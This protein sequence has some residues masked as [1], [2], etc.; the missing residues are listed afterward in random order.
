MLKNAFVPL[1]A[2]GL[3]LFPAMLPAQEITPSVSAVPATAPITPNAERNAWRRR[4]QKY[5]FD[6]EKDPAF[7]N[8]F[9]RANPEIVRDVLTAWWKPGQ[10]EDLNLLQMLVLGTTDSSTVLETEPGG[11]PPQT[12]PYLLDFI[13]LGMQEKNRYQRRHIMPLTIAVSGQ[14]LDNREAFAVWRS[15]QQGKP[16]EKIVQE[17]MQHLAQEFIRAD[18][19]GKDELLET[20]HDLLTALRSQPAP[21]SADEHPEDLAALRRRVLRESGLPDALIPLLSDK[22]NPERADN[23][24][25]LLA[26]LRPD[27]AILTR[28]EPE[29]RRLLEARYKRR[30]TLT[31]SLTDLLLAY[32]SD[33]AMPLMVRFLQR[34]GLS[35]MAFPCSTPCAAR[36]MS[37]PC[38]C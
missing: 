36:K 11:T 2:L 17:G 32:S 30:D 7:L 24:L 23:A 21:A 14:R 29:A 18:L 6:T 12:N 16:L 3:A 13:A 22:N 8:E 33:W 20:L 10:R 28:I 4:L 34:D 19:H 37:A 35:P 9:A 5:E 26:A 1:A 25:E 27:Q 15:G 31:L 38:P